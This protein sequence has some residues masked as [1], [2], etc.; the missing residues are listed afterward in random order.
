MIGLFSIPASAAIF[1]LVGSGVAHHHGLDFRRQ[2]DSIAQW[3]LWLQ[4]CFDSRCASA[5]SSTRPSWRVTLYA[6]L[7]TIFTVIVQAALDTRGRRRIGIPTFTAP[8]VFATWLFLLPKAK[9]K[10][11]PHEEI[12]GGLSAS[13]RAPGGPGP[14]ADLS[15]ATVWLR[16]PVRF[17]LRS[18]RMD[19]VFRVAAVIIGALGVF[20][21]F[22]SIV[23][24]M[25]INRREHD[26]VEIC[27]PAPTA[28]SFIHSLIGND[29]DYA[30]TQ[31]L[32]AW[33]LPIFH[34]H[35]RRVLVPSCTD[36]LHLHSLGAQAGAGLSG[37][38]SA[39]AARP[40]ARS[41]IRHRRI[42]SVSISRSS[43]PALGSPLSSSCSPSFRATRAAVQVRERKVGWLYA[44][45]GQPSDHVQPA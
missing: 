15:R 23:R 18:I 28:V 10:P 22:R 29:S 13:S 43:K 6:L 3:P 45:T 35:L 44:R 7:G 2:P 34:L 14:A 25:L 39:P 31:R 9:L 40:S 11:H 16:S 19:T 41:A 4:S 21:Y 26:F 27:S 42:F 12:K 8:F 17:T 5:A 32:Q 38:L 30:R 33:V 20:Y 36:V 24:V 37:R 1:A